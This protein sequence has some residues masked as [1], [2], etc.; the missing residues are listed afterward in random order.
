MHAFMKP[1]RSYI[2]YTICSGASGRERSEIFTF[3]MEERLEC[4]RCKR[5][6]YRVD[7]MDVVS[8]PVPAHRKAT[9]DQ[10]STDKDGWE[11]VRFEDCL[12][13]LT[14]PETLEYGCPSCSDRVFARK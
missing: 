13:L 9:S 8:V 5:V 14:V 12:A 6:R 3:G 2:A 11:P 4:G 7:K 10:G 1:C